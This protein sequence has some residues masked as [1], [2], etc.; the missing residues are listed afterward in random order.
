MRLHLRLTPNTEPIPFNYQ[1][2]LTGAL[3]KWLGQ[4]DLHDKISLYSFSWLRGKVKTTK[5]GLYFPKGARWFISFWEKE[6]GSDLIQ[7]IINHPTVA[8]GMEVDEVQVVR[9]PKFKEEWRFK[10]SSPVLVRKNRDDHSREH[11]TYK[12]EDVGDYLKRTLTRKLK[13]ADVNSGDFNVAFDTSYSGARTKLIHI[14][15]TKLKANL[16][17]IIM[18]GDPKSIEFAWNVGIGELTGSGFGAVC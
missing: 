6:Y 1:H 15:G 14:K 7:G 3:H 8:F 17:P 13:E 16:C 4:N 10:V 18:E 11:L 9:L 2:Q 5:K 12:D